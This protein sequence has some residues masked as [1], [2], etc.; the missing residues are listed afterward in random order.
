MQYLNFLDLQHHQQ[1]ENQNLPGGHAVFP[2]AGRQ[3]KRQLSAH[4]CVGLRLNAFSFACP[5]KFFGKDSEAYLTGELHTSG[6]VVI[7][8]I[9][10]NFAII[11]HPFIASRTHLFPPTVLMRWS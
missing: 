3:R 2:L 5:V 7:L 1:K 8:N 11:P 6:V 4:V 9:Y 10:P